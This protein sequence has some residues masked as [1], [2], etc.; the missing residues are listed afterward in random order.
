MAHLEPASTAATAEA[1]SAVMIR[2]SNLKKS[3]QSGDE[4]VE[5]LRGV[6]LEIERGSCTFI[7]GP[8]GSGKSTLLYL[9]GALDEPSSGEIS[10]EGQTV[11]AMSETDRDHFRRSRIGFVFQQFNLIPNLDAVG[12]VLLPFI[13]TGLNRT[14][15][16]KAVGLLE[17]VG[18]GHRLRHRPSRLSGG[19]QQRVAI[20]RAL[21]KD[22]A[23][24][25]ADEPTGNLD[26]KGADEIFEIL[27]REQR[28][29]GRTLVVVTHDRRFIR[30]GDRVIEILDGKIVA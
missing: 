25:L 11:T 10:I 14:L 29:H 21:V 18:L 28:V 7:V 17:D 4:L 2:V 5:A 9:L 20:A 27:R 26:H 1:Q 24:L 23:I 3:F 16:N 15:R 13:P 8:S 12:N 30:E 22:P 19:Q 6:D